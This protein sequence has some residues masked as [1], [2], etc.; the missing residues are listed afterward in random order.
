MKRKIDFTP[1]N[2]NEEYRIG[3]YALGYELQQRKQREKDAK[4]GS[5][6]KGDYYWDRW[7]TTGKY[8]GFNLVQVCDSIMNILVHTHDISTLRRYRKAAEQSK[9][10]L[11]TAVKEIVENERKAVKNRSI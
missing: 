10:Q 8:W 2:I 3:K 11:I 9:N 5:Y 4:D 6:K 7:G 1:V